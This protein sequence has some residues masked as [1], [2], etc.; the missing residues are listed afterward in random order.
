MRFA[1]VMQVILGT[2]I[3]IGLAGCSDAPS[4]RDAKRAIRKITGN[5][6]YFTLTHVLK[7]NWALPGSSDYQVDVQY[8]I[9]ALALPDAKNVTASFMAP[10][11]AVN[12]RLA[13]ASTER[14]RNFKANADF[15]G[16]IE[17]AQKAGDE[18]LARS[19]EIQR[20]AFIRQQMEPS[21]KRARD[22][23]EEKA[24]MI[25]QGTTPLREEFFK[26]CPNTSQAVYEKIYDNVDIAPYVDG[27]TVDFAT[28]IRMTKAEKGWAVRQ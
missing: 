17:S 13:T 19:T 7:V 28:S 12:A 14:D 3:L 15:L 11:A 26:T 2:V 22:L 23:T 8:S 24:A 20:S 5:C 4:E 9:E 21:L 27:R 25:R 1:N 6:K 18:T 10:L 16:R